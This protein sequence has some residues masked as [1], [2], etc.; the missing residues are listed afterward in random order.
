MEQN[1]F[2]REAM[3]LMRQAKHTVEEARN[4][5]EEVL[6]DDVL[7][8][9]II[10]GNEGESMREKTILEQARDK[11]AQLQKEAQAAFE[12]KQKLEQQAQGI[13]VQEQE[14]QNKFTIRDPLRLGRLFGGSTRAEESQTI[15]VVQHGNEKTGLT[16]D[17]AAWLRVN[18]PDQLPKP[19]PP[20]LTIKQQ[21]QMAHVDYVDLCNRLLRAKQ[22]LSKIEKRVAEA[23]EI[24]RCVREEA[25]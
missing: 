2:T 14:N 22:D 3:R 16:D 4:V 21:A 24:M 18:A 9:P 20:V 19:G 10:G 7:S 6:T 8:A 25:A 11:V 13:R 5:L 15:S 12:L 23:A 1:K 17:V